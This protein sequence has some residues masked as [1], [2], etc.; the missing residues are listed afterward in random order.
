MLQY[1]AASEIYS[2]GLCLLELVS[3]RPTGAHTRDDVWDA[4]EDSTNPMGLEGWLDPE[5]GK[6]RC[7]H[8]L[9]L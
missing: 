1:G 4:N 9:I 6:L 3:G 7:P 2:F 5:A 8:P